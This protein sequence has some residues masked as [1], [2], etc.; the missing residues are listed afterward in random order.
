MSA[1]FHPWQ[2]REFREGSD[3]IPSSRFL[4]CAVDA[5]KEEFLATDYTDFSGL[6]A[7]NPAYEIVD[8]HAAWVDRR[9]LQ[10]SVKSCEA[11]AEPLLRQSVNAH[12]MFKL[13]GPV[14]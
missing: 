1:V 5:L 4:K 14:R 13:F 6:N 8:E 10:R 9:T 2:I 7:K 12:N 3:G 11:S